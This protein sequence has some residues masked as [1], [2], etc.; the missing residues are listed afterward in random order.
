MT[1]SEPS[2]AKEIAAAVEARDASCAALDAPVS[3]GDVGARNATLSIMVGGNKEAFDRVKPLFDVM[4][5]NVRYR[6]AE[7]S[8]T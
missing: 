8:F 4:G 1:T 6:R 5:K 3:G 7:A 2:L